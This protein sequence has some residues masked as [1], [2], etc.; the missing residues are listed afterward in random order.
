MARRKKDDGAEATAVTAVVEAPPE[1]SGTHVPPVVPE[2]AAPAQTGP[3]TNRPVK[4]IKVPVGDGT[5]IEGNIWPREI[6]LDGKVVTVYSV[7]IGKTYRGED[8]EYRHTGSFRGSE[9]P[10]V[11]F[12]L[13]CCAEWILAQRK[14]EDPTF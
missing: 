5:W 2:S 1:Q 3:V 10:V 6:T 11:Q 9:I 8:E 4:A 14:E 12:V 13:G 7:T